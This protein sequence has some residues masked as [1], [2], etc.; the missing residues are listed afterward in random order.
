MNQTNLTVYQQL[1][2]SVIFKLDSKVTWPSNFLDFENR[3]INK[4]SWQQDQNYGGYSNYG[5]YSEGQTDA[6]IDMFDDGSSNPQKP[7]QEPGAE[8]NSFYDPNTYNQNQAS[9]WDQTQHTD[10]AY[11]RG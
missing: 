3:K 6:A 7:Y 4:M 9:S 8:S 10:Q 5:D 2:S 1:C 11:Q